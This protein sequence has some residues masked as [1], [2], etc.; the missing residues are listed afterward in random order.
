MNKIIRLINEAVFALK[1]YKNPW[2]Y[3]AE[4]CGFF[5]ER[6]IT[7]KLRNG[8]TYNIHTNTSDVRILNELWNVGIYDRLKTFVGENGTV[9]DIGGHVGVLSVK[10][11]MWGANVKVYPYEPMPQN[12]DLLTSNIA[13]NN[14]QNRVKP[15][16]AAVADQ[17]GS[18]NLYV[19]HHDSGGGSL[20]KKD[21][22][23]DGFV[24]TVKTVTLESI[25]KTHNIEVC[26]FM[27]VDCEGGEVPILT[28]APRELFKRI[29]SLSIEWHNDLSP[30]PRAEFTKFLEDLGY[31]VDFDE[32]TGTIYAARQ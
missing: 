19:K 20:Y 25:F 13:V 30:I 4:R 11:A 27:K 28:K 22:A 32:P 1:F 21:N 17:E 15:T 5:G 9:I 23:A 14:L 7:I 18:L 26:D 24:I 3:I 2:T 12:F 31:K 6:I 16:Q 29:R 8:I 10:A